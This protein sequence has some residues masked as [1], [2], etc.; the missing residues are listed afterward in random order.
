MAPALTGLLGVGA[1]LPVQAFVV[2]SGEEDMFVTTSRDVGDSMFELAG[3]STRSLLA[4][5]VDDGEVSDEDT[6]PIPLPPS[7][8]MLGTAAAAMFN[9]RRKCVDRL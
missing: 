4:N 6:A 7:V 1:T 5:D 9:I 3:G 2:T 8:L